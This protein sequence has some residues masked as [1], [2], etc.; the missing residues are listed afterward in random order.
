MRLGEHGVKLVRREAST[1]V[2]GSNA[3]I[4]P[5]ILT[6]DVRHEEPPWPRHEEVLRNRGF[7]VANLVEKEWWQSLIRPRSPPS[8]EPSARL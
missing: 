1:D 3:I 6:F 5:S 2:A 7:A 8:I 4:G